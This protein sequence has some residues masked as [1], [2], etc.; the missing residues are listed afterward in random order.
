M[1]SRT[2]TMIARIS[3]AASCSCSSG[4]ALD[5][6]AL[7]SDEVSVLVKLGEDGDLQLLDVE[8]AVELS[9]GDA[10]IVQ[11]ATFTKTADQ[12]GL[13][14]RITPGD[15]A[16][17]PR[18]ADLA[19]RLLTVTGDDGTFGPWR[20][21]AP[22][23]AETVLPIRRQRCSSFAAHPKI[24][25]I[26]AP[27]SSVVSYAVDL[28]DGSLLL[29]VDGRVFRFRP[30]GTHDEL[31]S[32]AYNLRASA[33]SI[34]G[35]PLVFGTP[36]GVLYGTWTGESLLLAPGPAWNL[37][38]T[39]QPLGDLSWM[40]TDG[41]GVIGLTS[42]GRLVRTSSTGARDLYSF[43]NAAPSHRGSF[44]ARPDGSVALAFA[45][46]RRPVSI[47][48]DLVSEDLGEL[49]SGPSALIDLPGVGLLSGDAIGQIFRFGGMSWEALA[50]S[51][52]SFTINA[53][54][55]FHD[56][57]VIATDKGFVGEL[58]REG[59]C[60]PDQ[61]IASNIRFVRVVDDGVWVVGQTNQFGNV[62]VTFLRPL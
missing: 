15:P 25:A 39:G 29:G 7:A 49:A 18:V 37:A 23:L 22:E 13:S 14:G 2:R 12:L 46:A 10:S 19:A 58:D 59:F 8:R 31:P 54:E 6:L 51:P 16:T 53:M 20:P 55:R 61:L 57:I 5:A 21:S 47:R 42:G 33:A 62:D 56:G 41:E 35:R 48:G 32:T 36:E 17:D 38:P 50:G 34:D 1:G 44:T 9:I 3:A 60:A 24:D 43:E 52:F 28:P 26:D 45:G 40:W 27:G 4:A 30:E 11:V